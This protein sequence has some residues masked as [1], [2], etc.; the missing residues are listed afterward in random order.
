MSVIEIENLGNIKKAS[1]EIGKL[2]I[3]SGENN[4]GKTYLNYV[5]YAFLDQRFKFRNKI[6]LDIAREGK[7]KGTLKIELD[8]FLEKNYIKLK[9]SMELAFKKS[10]DNFF[11]AEENRFK[12]FQLNITN[13][14]ENVKEYIFKQ[15]IESE[16]S[17]GKSNNTICE[18]KKE[19]ES[20]LTHIVFFDSDAPVDIY[21]DYI[22]DILIRYIFHEMFNDAF[23]LPAERTGINLFY[24]ELNDK[25]NALINHLQKSSIEPLDVIRDLIIS[26][27]PQPIADYITFLN[28]L[29][30]LKKKRSP[31]AG[32]NDFLHKEIIQGKY[33]VDKSGNITFK[34]YKRFFN[35]NGF[36]DKIDLHL[37]SSA[38][39]TFFSLEFYIEHMA[40]AGNYLIIDEP[41]L[42]LHPDNQRKIARLLAR[43]VNKGV[44]VILSTHSDYIVR[45]FN[46]LI[47]LHNEFDSKQKIME[48][49]GYE[50]EEILDPKYVKAYIVSSG[51][52]ERV[53]IDDE[54]IIMKTFDDVINQLNESSDE[55]FY[56]MKEE[57]DDER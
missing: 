39:K 6:F 32:L 49:Y 18:I 1:L 30:N 36:S 48:S 27:Y 15:N 40:Q 17:I 8:R 53:E 51:L 4:S 10:L 56:T 47:M 31:F 13:S 16:L 42:N 38:V 57:M 37:S 33:G 19:K 12:N 41:E 50:I 2:T 11:S 55:I 43:L 35:G 3:F 22:N 7:E 29:N 46:N 54:G 5:L 28:N 45:E 23:L 21:A 24:Q 25:R 34:P 52:V 14:L 20:F 26:K 9:N 44:N